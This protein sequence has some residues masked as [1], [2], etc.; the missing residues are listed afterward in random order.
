MSNC[1]KCNDKAVFDP[2]QTVFE[3]YY[4]PQQVNVI[5]QV[6]VVRRHHCVPVYC[7][8]TTVSVEDVYCG[9]FEGNNRG[10]QT[11]AL[12]KKR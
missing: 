2:P 6:K 5:H 9:D 8:T 12:R 3:D 7:H 4:H 1:P 11:S 10:A